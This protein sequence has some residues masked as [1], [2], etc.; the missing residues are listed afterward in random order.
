MMK[1]T[2]GQTLCGFIVEQ[3]RHIREIGGD[4]YILRHERSGAKLC[5][6]DCDDRNMTYSVTFPTPSHDSTGVFHI[7]EHSVLCGSE[8]YPVDDPFVELM[9]GSLYTFLNAMTFPDKTMY[10]VSSQNERDLMN[11]MSVYT[12]AVFR[13]LIYRDELA[14]RQEGWHIETDENGRPYY[15][16]VVYNEMKGALSDPE[17]ILYTAVF[18]ESYEPCQYT[19]VSGGHPDDIV[20]LTYDEFVATH[21]RYYH[22]SNAHFYLYGKLDLEEKLAFLDREYLSSVD[23]I[24]P[25]VEPP[26]TVRKQT[27]VRRVTYTAHEVK[28][29]EDYI[30]LTYPIGYMPDMKTM[31]SL[32]I[33]GS[34][35]TSSNYSPLKKRLLD[36]K[37]AVEVDCAVIEDLCYPLLSIKLQNA[38]SNKLDEICSEIDDCL[39]ALV[40][41]GIERDVVRSHLCTAEFTLREGA[42]MGLSKGLIYN[43]QIMAS[44]L[45]DKEPWLYLE[46]ESALDELKKES[47]NGLFERLIDTYMLD[48]AY[49]NTVVMTPCIEESKYRTPDTLP[50]GYTAARTTD[51]STIPHLYL[52]DIDKDV[53]PYHNELVDFDGHR[54][55]F[56]P[57]KT[58]G[59]VYLNL[60]FDIGHADDDELFSL[61]LLI[62]LL[63]NLPTEHYSG[64]ELQTRLGLYT[65]SLTMGHAVSDTHSG[66][67]SVAALRL[68]ALEKNFGDAVA[69]TEEILCHTDLSDKSLVRDIISQTYNDLTLSLINN[70]SQIA[71]SRAAAGTSTADAIND[72]M[73]GIALY[74]RMREL[75]DHLDE[76]LDDTIAEMGKVYEKFIRQ[77]SAMMSIACDRETFDTLQRDVLTRPVVT[78][79][80][81]ATTPLLHGNIALKT[82]SDIVFNGYSADLSDIGLD[83][84]A[85]QAGKKILSLEYLWDVIRVQNGAYG[86]GTAPTRHRRLDF[87]SYRDPQIRS[88]LSCFRG[89]AAFLQT[90]SLSRRQLEDYIIGCIRTLDSPVTPYQE[91]L[92]ADL[93]FLSGKTVEQQQQERDELLAVTLDDLHTFGDAIAGRMAD[94][95]YCTVGNAD[96]IESCRELYDEIIIM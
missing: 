10:P 9:K 76:R 25:T 59:I 74:R 77:G 63:S 67:W 60:L 39:R 34:I 19:T 75:Y 46:Y 13:P 15:Q 30:A 14:F 71:K 47:E 96:L 54:V 83:L 26:V 41:D 58:D 53:V 69:L 87:W 78:S 57:I 18:R 16:G 4:L 61:S 89:A 56:H 95:A 7:L 32:N 66:V 44:W 5:Y 17:D 38:D 33:L 43:I 50:D 24:A 62:Q 85:M 22:P 20:S 12:D 11:L 88:T 55:L 29:G 28:K 42:G 36:K 92:L 82:P 84:G 70:A 81:P 2:I 48:N 65:G 73:S 31:L 79:L 35:L 37:L 3:K 49:A 80:A 6:I 94:G 45:Y 52:D 1:Y 51:E 8:K 27:E 86:C 91:A 90:L 21:R 40:R 93:S 23:A 72:K 68:K 64:K